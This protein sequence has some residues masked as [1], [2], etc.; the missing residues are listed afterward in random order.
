MFLV[1]VTVY[2]TVYATFVIL[3]GPVRSTART[4]RFSFVEWTGP[5]RMT[6][7]ELTVGYTVAYTIEFPHTPYNI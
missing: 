6:S 4:T 1:D 7:V 5:V 3:T 2:A